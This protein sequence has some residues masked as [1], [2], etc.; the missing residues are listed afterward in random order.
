[1]EKSEG[2][3]DEILRKLSERKDRKTSIEDNALQDCISFKEALIDN[4]E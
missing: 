1:M 3:S 4:L 2:N